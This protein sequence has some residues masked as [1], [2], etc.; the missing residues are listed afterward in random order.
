VNDHI[1]IE[2]HILCAIK[3][4]VY[5]STHAGSIHQLIGSVHTSSPES[6]DALSTIGSWDPLLLI[7]ADAEAAAAA[8]AGLAGVLGADSDDVLD[9]STT[10]AEVQFAHL[11]ML[12][13]LDAMQV[14]HSQVSSAGAAVAGAGVAGVDEDEAPPCVQCN[15]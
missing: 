11:L 15:G 14:R 2:V 13:G 10:R 6:S 3:E 5:V 1:I 7:T 9:D 4:Q 8:A 12:P